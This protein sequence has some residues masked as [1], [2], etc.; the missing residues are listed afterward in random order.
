MSG[1]HMVSVMNVIGLVLV[2]LGI[3]I[4][5]VA[6]PEQHTLLAATALLWRPRRR[7]DRCDG[8]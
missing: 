7:I 1:D 2:M 4:V 3:F 5:V 8:S 6:M